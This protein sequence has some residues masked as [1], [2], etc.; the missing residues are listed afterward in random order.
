[1]L[2]SAQRRYEV[3]TW[4]TSTRLEVACPFPSKWP[5]P[6]LST[7]PLWTSTTGFPQIPSQNPAQAI[8]ALPFSLRSSFPLSENSI[9]Q[10][11][12]IMESRLSSSSSLNQLHFSM[13]S[14][15]IRQ[16]IAC[17]RYG[18]MTT[19]LQ[20]CDPIPGKE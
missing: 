2:T 20:S 14:W 11:Q 19:R 4:E 13:P 15:K 16:D 9:L 12:H 8:T 7:S 17:T 10:K 3:G 5:S 6:F 18:L 1:M